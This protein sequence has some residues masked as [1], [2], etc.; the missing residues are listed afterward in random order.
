MSS[1]F[2]FDWWARL[3]S[4]NS[5]TIHFYSLFHDEQIVRRAIGNGLHTLVA[6]DITLYLVVELS[7]PW[8]ADEHPPVDQLL[9]LL[10]LPTT[11]YLLPTTYSCRTVRAAE[12]PSRKENQSGAKEK[13]K[14]KRRHAGLP[15][16][17]RQQKEVKE[18]G[19]LSLSFS[20]FLSFLLSV[21]MATKFFDEFFTSPSSVDS[22]EW[23]MWRT[24]G[25]RRETR[26]RRETSQASR[27]K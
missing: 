23:Q 1:F 16:H 7:K 20:L 21:S 9:L 14:L 13:E 5:F 4:F 10:L 22:F 11:Y 6:V 24:E 27:M 25:E 15:V 8:H 3:S 26:R 18:E 19:S 17:Y 12:V 2:L